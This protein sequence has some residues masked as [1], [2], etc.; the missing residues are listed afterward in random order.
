[1]A[2]SENRQ[3]SAGLW[4]FEKAVLSYAAFTLVLMALLWGKLVTPL[5]MLT[6]RVGIVAVTIGLWQLYRWKP[7]RLTAML[8]VTA[9]LCFLGWWYPD[10]YEFNRLFLNLDHI[11]A[12]WEQALFGCQP[13]LLFSQ[14]FPSP[15]FSELLCLGYVSY[16]PMIGAVAFYYFI[17]NYERFTYAAFVILASFFL[18]YVIFIFLP[19][20]GPQFYYQAVGFDQ[21]AQGVF[22]DMGH[23]F[24]NHQEMVPIPGGEGGLFHDL[25]QQAHN[26]GERPT[27]AFPSSHVGISVVLLWLAWEAHPKATLRHGRR[28]W[29]LFIPVAVLSLLMF[30]ATFYIQAHY[31]I[32]AIAGIFTGTAMYFLFRWVYT[33][34]TSRHFAT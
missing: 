22:P 25:V 7:C 19:V 24:L 31:A 5:P 12:G 26:A 10:T 32:D 20:A 18:F 1:M 3:Q 17:R 13:P 15:V 33:K 9:Q 11:F 34:W 4:L 21:I 30:F 23:Y 8:R 6:G 28:S 16:F 27:A 29:A 14:N 2:V